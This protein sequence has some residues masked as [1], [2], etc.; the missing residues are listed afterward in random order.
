MSSTG[1][2]G[3]FNTTES[4]HQCVLMWWQPQRLRDFMSLIT[5]TAGKNGYK[6]PTPLSPLH[7]VF[8]TGSQAKKTSSHLLAVKLELGL[9][10]QCCRTI[11]VYNPHSQSWAVF[12]QVGLGKVQ[13]ESS[14][15]PMGT[16]IWLA[17]VRTSSWVKNP[18]HSLK[19]GHDADVCCVPPQAKIEAITLFLNL[20]KTVCC[21]H[22]LVCAKYS[23]L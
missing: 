23:V 22:V 10:F 13:M 1:G 14:W 15:L 4:S 20:I 2:I 6:A 18:F 11:C 17:S 3:I 19:P 9:E 21:R 16:C 12:A 7:E 8:T 5:G